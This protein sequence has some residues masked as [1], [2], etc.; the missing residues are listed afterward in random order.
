MLILRILKGSTI[1]LKKINSITWRFTGLQGA[2]APDNTGVVGDLL[3]PQHNAA[4]EKIHIIRD[5]GQ[6]FRNVEKQRVPSARTHLASMENIMY[7]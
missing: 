6:F 1:L 2:Q 5:P 3:G 7:N 4:S